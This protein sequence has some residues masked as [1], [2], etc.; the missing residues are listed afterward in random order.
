MQHGIQCAESDFCDEIIGAQDT[1]F[2]SVYR[3]DPPSRVLLD[4]ERFRLIVDMSP[5]CA[6]HLLLI[7]V[8]H[9]LSFAELMSEHGA[10]LATI[11]AEVSD[12]YRHTFGRL[13]ILEHGSSSAMR[14]GACISH[15]H[16]HLLPVDAHD[17]ISLIRTDGLASTA[18]TDLRELTAFGG[19]PYFLCGHEGEYH[20]FDGS[21]PIRSQY[22]RSVVGRLLGIPDPLWDYALVVRQEL[23]RETMTRTHDWWAG[24]TDDE[25]SN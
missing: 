22:L 1:T 5:L 15:A 9:Y 7:P 14:S 13:T 24:P 17:V 23:L 8:D 21:R 18:L 4:T 25:P 10:E 2:S 3:G 12:R 6:G 19:E 11:L 16:L 20:I